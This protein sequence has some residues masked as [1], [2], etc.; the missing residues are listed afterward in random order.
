MSIRIKRIERLW[1]D[2]RPI[3]DHGFSLIIDG[4]MIQDDPPC[5]C[6]GERITLIAASEGEQAANNQLAEAK[7]T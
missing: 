6:G 4:L 5:Q 1:N 2:G 3:C 7:T